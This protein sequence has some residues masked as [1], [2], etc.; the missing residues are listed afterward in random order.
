MRKGIIL[1]VATFVALFFITFSVFADKGFKI[2]TKT[3]TWAKLSWDKDSKAKYYQITY[4]NEVNAKKS[5]WETDMIEANSYNL[6]WLETGKTYYLSLIW[7]DENWAQVFKSQAL[8]LTL[9]NS[10]SNVGNFSITKAKL[11]SEKV[12]HLEFSKDLDSSKFKDAEFKIEAVKDSSDYLKVKE[13][14]SVENKN[15]VVELELD[16]TPTQDVEYKVTVLAIYDKSG[17]NIKFWVDSEV[18]FKWGEIETENEVSVEPSKDLNSADETKNNE[19][20][21]TEET[22]T[23]RVMV[24]KDFDSSNVGKNVEALS[25]TKEELPQTWPEMFIILIL[26]LLL[27]AWYFWLKNK[28]S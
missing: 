1:K 5:L 10:T 9:G 2:E 20:K 3:A 15:N 23:G 7:M 19:T 18:K 8:E 28:N 4:S 11:I 21:R 26:A 25:K 14:K 22:S 16:A 6:S 27:P 17:N 12:L 13:V 24:T